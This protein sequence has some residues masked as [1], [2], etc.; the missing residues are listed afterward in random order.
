MQKKSV[1]EE[2]EEERAKVDAKTPMTSDV[3]KMWKAEQ[4]AQ[5][6]KMEAEKEEER[7]KRGILTGREMFSAEGFVAQ[8]DA[9][10]SDYRAYM[11]E[12]DDEAEIQRMHQETAAALERARSD[13]IPTVTSPSGSQTA[14]SR[15]LPSNGP[16]PKAHIGIGEEDEEA[17]FADDDDDD[18]ALLEALTE[19]LAQ[20]GTVS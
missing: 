11:R 18:D 3:F 20:P 8:D 19:D 1:E 13:Q 16:G 17:L 2:I 15:V 7:R 12:V 14:Q 4:D 5:R 6:R 9:A 10:A